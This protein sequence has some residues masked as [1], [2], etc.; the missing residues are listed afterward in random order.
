MRRRA[1]VPLA[2]ALLIF[3]CT[4]TDPKPALPPMTKAKA[5]LNMGFQAYNHV[6]NLVNLGPRH[7]GS[8]GWKQGIEYITR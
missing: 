3:G 6:R 7:V 8:K 4:C 1:T 5:P 2:A